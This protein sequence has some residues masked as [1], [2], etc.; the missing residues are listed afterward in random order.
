MDPATP[1]YRD[2]VEVAKE[3]ALA[4]SMITH[5]RLGV[6]S[7]FLNLDDGVV[8]MILKVLHNNTL[9]NASG[10]QED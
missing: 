5:P 2:E 4:F 10:K 1:P 3:L 6:K 9:F 8:Q 7:A